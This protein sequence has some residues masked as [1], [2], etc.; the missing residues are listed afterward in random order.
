MK[1]LTTEQTT[2]MLLAVCKKIIDSK[3]LLTDTDSKIGDGDHGIGMEVGMKHAS[4]ALIQ[5][6]P[7][8]T[9]NEVFATTGMEMIGSMG[10]ASGVIF[11]TL[12]LTGAKQSPVQK[13][14]DGAQL[15]GMM[16]ISLD[17]IKKRG[18]AAVGD[19]TMVDALEPAVLAIEKNKDNDLTVIFDE[20]EK[21]AAAGVEN[22]KKYVAKY[23]RAKSLKERAVGF[24][25]AGAT[26]VY[27]IFQ[28]MNEYIRSV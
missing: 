10:G 12:F 2:D 6:R 3:Q 19:K 14:L 28:A 1:E 26:S 21:A 27:L 24:Q 8:T 5:K 18:G 13:V 11:G 7:F 16:R 22:T 20:A 4:T 15:A 9:V 23:G 25:D 17:S